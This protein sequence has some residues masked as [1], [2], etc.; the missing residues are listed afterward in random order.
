MT[1]V[2]LLLPQGSIKMEEGRG[3]GES[4][5]SKMKKT[6]GDAIVSDFEDEQN[7]AEAKQCEW[8]PK[9]RKKR[10]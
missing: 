6:L 10:A 5:G 3:N 4:G 9:A 7:G 1:C 2:I 8:T